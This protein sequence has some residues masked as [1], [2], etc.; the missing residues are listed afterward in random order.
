MTYVAGATYESPFRLK[1]ALPPG[2]LTERMA[3]PWQADFSACDELSCQRSDPSTT[4][5]KDGIQS[6]SSGIRG[7]DEGNHDMVRCWTELG[8]VIKRVKNLSRTDAAHPE[9]IPVE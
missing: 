1:H 4:I 8:F 5:T 7:G 3:P 6:F 2:F 9:L